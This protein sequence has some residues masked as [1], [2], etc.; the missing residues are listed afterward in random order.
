ME[1]SSSRTLGRPDHHWE[2]LR[3]GDVVVSPGITMTDAHLVTWAGL[4]GDNVSLH[5][6]DDY[7]AGTPFGRRLAHGPMTLALSLGY[8]THTG[9]FS[10]VVAW[11]GLDE[12]RATAPVFVGDT[13]HA[14]A[15]CE[16]ARETGKADRGLWTLSYR[17]LKGDGTL[18]MTF[19][20]SFLIQR[21]QGAA[22]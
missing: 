17:V 3:V 14:E 6:D 10:N 12:V 4:T 8:L 13:L 7:A 16:V 11:L 15:T 18:V 1:Q 9:Y 22:R 2:D 21:R 19:R 20:S 5:L